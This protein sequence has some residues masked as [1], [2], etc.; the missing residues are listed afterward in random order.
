MENRKGGV[1][2]LAIKTKRTEKI[3]MILLLPAFSILI[4]LLI[5][6]YKFWK[7]EKRCKTNIDISRGKWD[8]M[9]DE[10]R[11]NSDRDTFEC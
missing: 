5:F 1:A 11:L 6:S 7:E 2:A 3:K 8:A 9:T 4:I 10:Q